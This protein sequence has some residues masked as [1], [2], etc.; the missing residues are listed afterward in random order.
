MKEVK[1]STKTV[2]YISTELG[3]TKGYEYKINGC[4]VELLEKDMPELKKN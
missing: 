3:A 1:N 4:R 2:G